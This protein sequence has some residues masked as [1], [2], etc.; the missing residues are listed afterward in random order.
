VTK[1]KGGLLVSPDSAESLA[2]GILKVYREPALA[3]ELSQNGFR[4]V[5]AHYSVARMADQALNV[6][7]LIHRLH[8]FHRYENENQGDPNVLSNSTSTVA[9]DES[10]KSA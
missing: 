3:E 9:A 1:T 5:R 7:E 8:R 4:N 6:Y 2:A 10:V